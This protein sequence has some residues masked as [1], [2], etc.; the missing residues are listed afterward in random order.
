[1]MGCVPCHGC[2]NAAWWDLDGRFLS[3]SQ[4]VARAGAGPSVREGVFSIRS[5]EDNPSVS[6]KVESGRGPLATHT[7]LHGWT[8][9]TVRHSW[10]PIAS[11]ER[12]ESVAAE[13]EGDYRMTRRVVLEMCQGI[14]PM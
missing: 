11:V 12:P 3:P 7:S 1:M 8:A 6:L 9:N 10:D 14:R 5:A 13:R 4:A 2:T